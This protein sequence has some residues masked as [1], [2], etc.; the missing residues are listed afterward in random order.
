VN[1]SERP[2]NAPDS[3]PAISFQILINF[4]YFKFQIPVALLPT[5]AA[6]TREGC[7]GVKK[8][9]RP[10]NAPDSLPDPIS[11]LI[12]FQISNPSRCSTQRNYFTPSNERCEKSGRTGQTQASLASQ[13]CCRH[14]GKAPKV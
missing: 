13:L 6:V 3:I 5:P 12:K 2:A 7:E 14:R 8:S 11:N 10:S 1:K 9:Q 4:K